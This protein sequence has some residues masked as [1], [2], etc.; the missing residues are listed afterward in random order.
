MYPPSSPPAM[1]L[2]PTTWVYRCS[3]RRRQ[4]I[5]SINATL[6]GDGLA[7]IEIGF[8]VGKGNGWGW[9][10]GSSIYHGNWKEGHWFTWPHHYSANA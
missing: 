7:G 9:V 2:F 1:C 6:G 10:D 3:Q 8:R 5:L 4:R